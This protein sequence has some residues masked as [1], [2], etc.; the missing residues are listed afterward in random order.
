[1]YATS[2]V[3]RDEFTDV[4]FLNLDDGSVMRDLENI[5]LDIM[6]RFIK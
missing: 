5:A 1:M 4:F 3:L 6:V 2:Q